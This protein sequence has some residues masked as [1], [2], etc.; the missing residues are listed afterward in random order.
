[1]KYFILCVFYTIIVHTKKQNYYFAQ[2]IILMLK[3][4][5]LIFL[6]LLTAKG[7][8]QFSDN[9]SDG[10]FTTNPV[11]TDNNGLFTIDNFQLRSNSPG[12]S[13][14]SI[15]TPSTKSIK[16]Q[17]EF[18][19]N[20][21]FA[22]SGSNYV[23]VFLMSDNADLSLSQN[24]YFVQL[25]STNDDISLYKIV[26]GISTLLIDG[27][28][29]LISSSSNN[30][31]KL[32]ITRDSNNVWQ[33]LYDKN[34][35]GSFTSGGSVSDNS[36]S[37]SSF[38]GI[39]IVQSS[40]SSVINKHFFDDFW[41]GDI[42]LD[43]TPPNV[44]GVTVQAANQLDVLFNEALDQ[45][46]AE[47]ASNYSVNQSIGT[48]NSATLDGTNPALV[49]L[50]FPGNFINLQNYQL[51][52]QNINDISLNPSTLQINSFTFL[53][54]DT[55]VSGDLIINEFMC[56]PSPVV[57]LPEIEFVELY[58]K[59]NKVFHVK[60]W[61][62]CDNSTCGTV[63]DFWILPHQYKIFIPIGS[64]SLYPG[65]ITVNAFPSLNN[66]EDEIIVKDS[67]NLIIDQIN[68]TDDWYHD[69]NKKNGGYSVERINPNHPC[70]S[71]DNWHASS[72]STGGSPNFQN[73][74]FDTT[75]DVVA[76]LLLSAYSDSEN[77]LTLKFSEA[78][79]STQL[80]TV[81][82]QFNPMFVINMREVNDAWSNTLRV[83]VD[84]QFVPG[85]NYDV[86]I[87]GLS[88]C[89][90]NTNTFHVQ[91]EQPSIA[92]NGDI[93]INEILYNP[94]TGGSDYVELY[95]NSTK[96]INLKNWYLATYDGAT[97]SGLKSVINENY[98]IKSGQYVLISEDSNQVKMTY[99]NYGWGTFVQTDMPSYSN[100][101]GFV[102]I[103]S[104]DSITIDHVDYDDSWQ[105]H[106]LEDHKGKSLERINPSSPSNDGSNWQSASEN[107]SFGTPGLRNSQY[108][109]TEQQGK[110]SIEPSTFSPDNDG[111]QDF[112]LF[113]YALPQSGMAGNILIY[114]EMGQIVRNLCSNYYFS[115]SGFI[116][117]DGVQDDGS[118]APVGRYIVLFDVHSI[119]DGTKIK[120]R[121][122]IIINTKINH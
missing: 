115:A 81:N 2:F 101:K 73:S 46:S 121:K 52:T 118:K 26:G 67:N 114:N 45:A 8:A 24:A 29:G 12:A 37:I 91:F 83:Q 68:Y 113:N 99:P 48:P 3:R 111:Y 93:I 13:I 80:M 54:S 22:T 87:A 107:V 25:G 89:W 23:R 36:V 62:L 112:A 14:Y 117:W 116:K 19:F 96:T 59:T 94:L 15:S 82:I 95:N 88:D 102:Y 86:S 108:L 77:W 119:T 30:P 44:I 39:G 109:N 16:A 92:Q 71:S 55:V 75:A 105:F 61:K 41:V 50:S 51:S 90:G 56:D 6:L 74:V 5:L 43:T 60:N 84:G 9:F 63:G 42:V 53:V 76:P 78:L 100:D 104:N 106:L 21:S 20:L 66:T 4:Y 40:A 35:S 85:I 98:L 31:F 28:D 33:I 18:F 72:S 103:L 110:F 70:S 38:F 7:N 34:A 79:D 57:G 69:N 27:T 64:D 11:W 58:N 32:K 65:A 1:M 17:W 47:T 97:I 49:H 10:D 120:D 122:V